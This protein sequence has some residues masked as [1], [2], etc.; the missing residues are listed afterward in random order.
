LGGVQ[1][2]DVG[3]QPTDEAA[4]VAAPRL[5][6]FALLC[7]CRF[8]PVPVSVARS[9]STSGRPVSTAAPTALSGQRERAG[10][11]LDQPPV[12]TWPLVCGCPCS[13]ACWIRRMICSGDWMGSGARTGI[14]SCPRTT[15]VSSSTLYRVLAQSLA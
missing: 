8:V 6:H 14:G 2:F 5:G 1:L 4:E 10:P 3:G 12:P 11:A 9:S 7:A 13:W 15:M